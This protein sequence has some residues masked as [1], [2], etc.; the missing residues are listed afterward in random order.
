MVTPAALEVLEVLEV[1]DAQK[2]RSSDLCFARP[3]GTKKFTLSNTRNCFAAGLEIF[4]WDVREAYASRYN[5][6]AQ[7]RDLLVVVVRCY[8]VQNS[9]EASEVK[10]GKS[11]KMRWGRLTE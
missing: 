4:R 9:M 6:G 11:S 10:E 2:L 5:E 8:N 1:L 7:L 3:P